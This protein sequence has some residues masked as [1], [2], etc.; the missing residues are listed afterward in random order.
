M[1]NWAQ[2]FSEEQRDIR[3][4]PNHYNGWVDTPTFN[5]RFELTDYANKHGV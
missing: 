3:E 2:M 4:Q 1:N 5:D